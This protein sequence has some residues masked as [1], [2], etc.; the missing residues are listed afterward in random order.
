MT[1]L[2]ALISTAMGALLFGLGVTV[3][4]VKDTTK[5]CCKCKGGCDK[6]RLK[7]KS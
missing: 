7:L 1:V 2:V 6:V 3:R 5:T 4:L